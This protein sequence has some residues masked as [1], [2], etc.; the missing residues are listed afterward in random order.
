[1]R[2]PRREARASVSL[3]GDV[4]NP[5]PKPVTR[6]ARW[7]SSHPQAVWAWQCL[8]SALKRGLIQKEPCEVCGHAKVDA[9]HSDYS[10]PMAAAWLRR[11]HHRQLH[12]R[13]RG[14]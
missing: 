9:H 11:R 2:N 13:E 12:S 3:T 10:K 8:R 6:Q 1:M 5:T 14:K 7:Q 4:G